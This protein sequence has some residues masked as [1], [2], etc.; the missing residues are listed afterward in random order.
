MRIENLSA[1]IPLFLFTSNYMPTPWITCPK[2]RFHERWERAGGITTD[3]GKRSSLYIRIGE[4]GERKEFIK[5]IRGEPKR[6]ISQYRCGK[7]DVGW[8]G[9]RVSGLHDLSGA[10]YFDISEHYEL[11]YRVND[12]QC[13][14]GGPGTKQNIEVIASPNQTPRTGKNPYSLHKAEFKKCIINKIAGDFHGYEYRILTSPLSETNGE[15]KKKLEILIVD[16][17]NRICKKKPKLIF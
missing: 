6:Y 3:Y 11:K 16:Q 4:D 12:Y 15:T 7:Y 8:T 5:C 9:L 10:F 17:Y 1:I 13:V 14:R 2:D